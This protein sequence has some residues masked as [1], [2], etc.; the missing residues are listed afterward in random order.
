MPHP[1]LSLLHLAVL[2]LEELPVDILHGVPIPMATPLNRVDDLG[3]GHA[4]VDGEVDLRLV[5]GLVLEVP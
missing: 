4:D 1:L 3:A 5:G 2:V